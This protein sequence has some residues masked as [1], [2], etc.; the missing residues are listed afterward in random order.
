[1]IPKD[2]ATASQDLFR[3][4]LTAPRVQSN[5]I[6]LVCKLSEYVVI[7]QL[8]DKINKRPIKDFAQKQKAY[9]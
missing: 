8:T 9:G 6:I 3:Y 5:D 1:M 2:L 4:M 7:A